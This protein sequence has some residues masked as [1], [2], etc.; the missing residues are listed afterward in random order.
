MVCMLNRDRRARLLGRASI[1]RRVTLPNEANKFHTRTQTQAAAANRLSLQKLP[2]NKYKQKGFPGKNKIFFMS[3]A[4]L[5]SSM[6]LASPGCCSCVCG[7]HFPTI[8]GLQETPTGQRQVVCAW[9]KKD[10][11]S[12]LPLVCC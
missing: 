7:K 12:P 11:M 8:Q 9:G 3:R 4:K 10:T 2:N 6:P 1:P 5:F